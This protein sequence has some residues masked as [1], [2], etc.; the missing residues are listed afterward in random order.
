M[1]ECSDPCRS[2]RIPE[3][4]ET[5]P[6]RRDE[7]RRNAY[8]NKVFS[9]HP[10]IASQMVAAC[11]ST[12]H[13]RSV[14]YAGSG[15]N[16][17]VSSGNIRSSVPCVTYTYMHCTCCCAAVASLR[18]V[19]NPSSASKGE[20][21]RRRRGV[22][23]S[24]LSSDISDQV[25][26]H[27]QRKSKPTSLISRSIAATSRVRPSSKGPARMAIGDTS[28]SGNNQSTTALTS[29]Q[30][31]FT[32]STLFVPQLALARDWCQKHKIIENA[33]GRAGT[34]ICSVQL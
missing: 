6:N 12:R 26:H 9:P 27:I 24:G 4:A 25:I 7:A 30:T 21:R 11:R 18:P 31:F 32:S 3:L 17:G 28:N 1:Q 10:P 20:S 22:S 2:P 23:S 15:S 13:C 16:G 33:A 19:R 8:S 5:A 34:E 29:S 14:I